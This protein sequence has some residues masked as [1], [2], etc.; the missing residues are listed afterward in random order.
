MGWTRLTEPFTHAT[1]RVALTKADCVAKGV[2]FTA[3]IVDIAD[4]IENL[5]DAVDIEQLEGSGF[6]DTHY[7]DIALELACMWADELNNNTNT[8]RD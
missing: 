8:Q 5:L 6:D 7:S 2:D 3:L 1:F 4:T